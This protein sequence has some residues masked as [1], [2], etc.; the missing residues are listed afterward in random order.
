[1]KINSPAANDVGHRTFRPYPVVGAGAATC[2]ANASLAGQATFS[3]DFIQCGKMC[4]HSDFKLSGFDRRVLNGQERH[5]ADP[6][7]GRSLMF[8]HGPGFR[9]VPDPNN[10]MILSAADP[11]RSGNV[12][13][14]LALVRMLGPTVGSSV[15]SVSLAVWGMAGSQ[16]ALVI[17]ASFAVACAM[18]GFMRQRSAIP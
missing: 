11:M 8:N 4:A 12:S 13:G 1:M 7:I 3:L 5:L 2:Y 15:V 10:R 9:P 18:I 6:V 16:H 14:T 17:S